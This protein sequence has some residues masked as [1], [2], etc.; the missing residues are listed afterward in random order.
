MLIPSLLAPWLRFVS[1]VWV[2]KKFASLRI[3]DGSWAV[4]LIVAASQVKAV[5]L[6]VQW[7]R[8]TAS[9]FAS[10][11][12]Q[13]GIL[14]MKGAIHLTISLHRVE[15]TW[16][17]LRVPRILWW[18]LRELAIDKKWKSKEITY[19]RSFTSCGFNDR[20]STLQV[21]FFPHRL[22]SNS[23]SSSLF[24]FTKQNSNSVS[25]SQSHCVDYLNHS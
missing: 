16:S 6:D 15:L 3:V 5:E 1:S 2:R 17:R 11:A 19:C 24:C 7:W 12:L 18:S 9:V 25:F 4:T 21:E 8:R 22:H 23:N 10:Y 20:N 14:F 13:L